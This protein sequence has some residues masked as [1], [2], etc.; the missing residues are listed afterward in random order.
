MRG[1]PI[2]V[3]GLGAVCAVGN[4][5]AELRAAIAEGRSGLG[6]LTRFEPGDGLPER[7]VGEVSA[8][9]GD[10]RQGTVTHRLA[11]AAAL[12]ACQQAAIRAPSNRIAVVCG[13]TTGG[14]AHSE[15]WFLNKLAFNDPS[16]SL[17]THHP[18]STVTEGVAK[19]IGASGPRLT[20][21]TACSSGANAI[22]L[23]AD[24]LR[25]GEADVVLAGGADALTMITYFGFSSLRLLSE[26]PCRPFDADR[27]GL[28]LGEAGAFMVL[29]RGDDA[30]LR[31]AEA[32]AWLTG[33]A[34]NCDAHHMTAPAPDGGRVIAC[35]QSAIAAAGLGSGDIAYV[36]AHGTATKANDVA[37][38]RAL[39]AVF[40]GAIPPV[41]SSKSFLG[42]TLGA[43]GAIEAVITA[44]AGRD[45]TLPP[46]LNTETPD[47]AAPADLVLGHARDADV[48]HAL[49]TAFAFGGNNT[50]LVF[51]R[52]RPP[53]AE[54]SDG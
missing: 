32:Q 5:I 54:V 34:C 6:P 25:A 16:P 53:Q 36:N 11:I 14:I 24:L 20:I 39:A 23:G 9:P 41:S 8:A 38:S 18:A 43:A 50:A 46:T 28:N 30:Y 33:S 29:E 51:S 12:E 22:A 4:N 15:V 3:T 37:E 26:S 48:P 1:A 40:G 2:A 10:Q 42:H 17:L 44:L 19:A 49:S 27:S 7:P 47:P 31:G 13:T 52:E 21:S 35:V 45:G